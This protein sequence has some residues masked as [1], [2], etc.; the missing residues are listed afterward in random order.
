MKR[1]STTNTFQ[2]GLQMDFNPLATP[3]GVI[4]NA[5]NATLVTMNGNENA[6]QNDMGN[7][8]VETA[9]LPEGY[10]PV[11][12]TE[13]GGIVYIVSYNPFTKKSQIG[14]FPSPER[15]FNS[16]DFNSSTPLSINCIDFYSSKSNLNT[17]VQKIILLDQML[18]PGDKYQILLKA[19]DAIMYLSAYGQKS[20]FNPDLLPRYIKLNVV[21]INSSGQ[22]NNLNSSLT[23][24]PAE[25]GYFY[26][27]TL[28]DD[29]NTT[30][31]DEYRNIV[32]SNY[33]IFNSKYSGQLG[34]IAELEYINSFSVSYDY[35]KNED[36]ILFYFY[37][38]WTYSNES[39]QD[40]INLYGIQIDK[41]LGSN[42][43]TDE[44]KLSYPIE[45]IREG[46]LDRFLG[47]TDIL[48]YQAIDNDNYKVTFL[49]PP[50]IDNILSIN[51]KNSI[52]KNKLDTL[53]PRFNNGKDFDFLIEQP[54]EIT[55]QSGKNANILNLEVTPSMPYGYLSWLKQSFQIDLNKL[56]TG[57]IHL[58]E[59][60]YFVE[61]NYIRL[62]WG[63]EAYPERNKKIQNV[64]FNFKEL[65]QNVIDK[66]VILSKLG[67][68]I[69]NSRIL[70]SNN[71]TWQQF[72]NG[73]YTNI[74]LDQE[75][76]DEIEYKEGDELII[77]NWDNSEVLD[78]KGSYSGHF[79]EL[80]DKNIYNN[81]CYLVEI[82]I[83]YNS[84]KIYKYYRI[85]Y[86]DY[87]F[88]HKY[89]DTNDFASLK[90]DEVNPTYLTYSNNPSEISN[91]TY[92]IEYYVPNSNDTYV[93]KVQKYKYDRNDTIQI[94][95]HSTYGVN[96]FKWEDEIYSANYDN[97]SLSISQSGDQS[98]TNI[99][100]LTQTPINPPVNRVY[101]QGKQYQKNSAGIWELKDV[102]ITDDMVRSFKI[103]K[104]NSVLI[105]SDPED[106]TKNEIFDKIEVRNSLSSISV[107][108]HLWADLLFQVLYN[109][110]TEVTV[111]YKLKPLDVGPGY[112][113]YLCNRKKGCSMVV[114]EYYGEHIQ[115]AKNN[116]IWYNSFGDGASVNVD[117]HNSY[118][119]GLESFLLDKLNQYD[120]LPI[121][122]SVYKEKGDGFDM[123]LGLGVISDSNQRMYYSGGSPACAYASVYAVKT[124]WNSV[125]LIALQGEMP[126]VTEGGKRDAWLFGGYLDKGYRDTNGT[127]YELNLL[128]PI[129]YGGF[130]MGQSPTVYDK[131]MQ[132]CFK[133]YARYYYK[134]VNTPSVVQRYT[135]NTLSYL[136]NYKFKV[137]MNIEFNNRR[138]LKINDV[139]I[140]TILN[141]NNF[142]YTELIDQVIDYNFTHAPNIQMIINRF[143]VQTDYSQ[144]YLIEGDSTPIEAPSGISLTKVYSKSGHPVDY[145]K[146]PEFIDRYRR[147]PGG[148]IVK[149]DDVQN[150]KNPENPDRFYIQ[151]QNGRLR[152]TSDTG[153]YG[154]R[155]TYVKFNKTEGQRVGIQGIRMIV[156]YGY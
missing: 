32:Q 114:S 9:Y 40:K 79:S 120:I 61:T 33:N 82:V 126:T 50:Y 155:T 46:K 117:I 60:R 145:F 97:T 24:Q 25:D 141:I 11:G 143:Y 42:T 1:E 4:T 86:T 88:N 107:G 111:P 148:S 144:Y 67:I 23:W 41:K 90:L 49:S 137:F 139:E 5:L 15:N 151:I 45:Y 77:F 75:V 2:G 19:D 110:P 31:L 125:M 6:L 7:G 20:K 83:N 124:S 30:N 118:Q 113:L 133:K 138:I 105:P 39:S 68:T 73:D 136:D 12:T 64:T 140:P 14:C 74:D 43:T 59:Y 101:F 13:L 152:I 16:N 69:D 29:T 62:S 35:I 96:T 130:T 132:E 91:F 81:N 17:S 34:I 142:N 71:S 108:L 112:L 38:N 93:D 89:Y 134:F 57:Y 52:Y 66:L 8:R 149:S 103:N 58:S 48:Q 92:N 115:D 153:D 154:G 76:K 100:S 84:E 131:G 119:P 135:W 27:K 36:T 116:S 56:G 99:S 147:S 70:Q 85:L 104:N 109:R 3:N 44:I 150:W 106:E 98:Y 129:F 53:S 87:V 121:G 78:N 10:I 22:I 127:N 156:G 55:K 47:S 122:I 21:A 26:L 123:D 95:T 146:Y 63:L 18:N 51:S 54:V 80:L 72:N 128:P 28:S 65:N 102:E 37:V 94:Q